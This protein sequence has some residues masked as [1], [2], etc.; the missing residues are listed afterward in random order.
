MEDKKLVSKAREGLNKAEIE[1]ASELSSAMD[2]EYK[3]KV[4]S[5]QSNSIVKRLIEEYERNL[6][7]K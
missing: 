1:A 6:I 3:R 7:G 4:I 2:T 5:K